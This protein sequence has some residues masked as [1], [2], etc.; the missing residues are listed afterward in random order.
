LFVRH[1]IAL[2]DAPE[3]IRRAVAVLAAAGFGPGD[4]TLLATAAP[5]AATTHTGE[6]N[7]YAQLVAAT[8]PGAIAASLTARGVPDGEAALY[9]EGAR[10]GG[11]VLVVRAPTALAKW[12]LEQLN[13]L[14]VADI[15][16]HA[17][18]WAGA[19]P[20]AEDAPWPR[21]TAPR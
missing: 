3:P 18:R 15:D 2:L 13:A 20:P 9:A 12:A 10:R 8:A 19:P 4:I 6:E 16:E 11:T 21:T 14:G 17:A 7:G 1:V 5:E